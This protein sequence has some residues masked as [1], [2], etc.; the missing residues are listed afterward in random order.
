MR[1]EY[2]TI[3]QQF[4]EININKTIKLLYTVNINKKNGKITK[5]QLKLKNYNKNRIID[6]NILI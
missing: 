3:K 5:E 4:T 2:K 6:I 1:K